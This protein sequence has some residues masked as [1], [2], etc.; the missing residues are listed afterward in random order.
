MTS[1][2]IQC[3]AQKCKIKNLNFY[4]EALKYSSKKTLWA[5]KAI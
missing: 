2:T 1:G 4:M 3:I 5:L